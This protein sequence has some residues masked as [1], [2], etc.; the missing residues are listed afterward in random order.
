VLEPGVPRAAELERT[1]AELDLAVVHE[2]GLHDDAGHVQAARL[3]GGRLAAASDLR[4]DGAAAVLEC[5]S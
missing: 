3:A 4:A 1:A 2:P 5:S